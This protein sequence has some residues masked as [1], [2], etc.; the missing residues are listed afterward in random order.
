MIS[1]DGT[2]TST[3]YVSGIAG[4]TF[5][6]ALIE[7]C[8][9]AGAVTGSGLNVGGIVGQHV[10]AISKVEYCYAINRV[11]GYDEYI[12]GITERTISVSVTNFVT[13]NTG[14]AKLVN[15]DAFI[16]RITGGAGTDSSL[17]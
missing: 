12:G 16:M 4:N 6:G 14:I 7:N 10:S 11:I 17:S 3:G 15:S 8:Y 2:V 13:L 5:S 1:F 9:A